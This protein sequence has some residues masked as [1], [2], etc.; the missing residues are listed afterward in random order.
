MQ[1]TVSII[2]SGKVQGVFYRQSTKE[3]ANSLGIKGQVKNRPDDTVEIIATGAEEQIEKL[4][5][6]CRIGPP[7]A[8]V[9]SVVAAEL[10]LTV[11]D[12]FSIAR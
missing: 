11:F 9:S 8:V 10:P 3:L 2:V 4:I 1:K 5:Q 7:K 6:W 12:K